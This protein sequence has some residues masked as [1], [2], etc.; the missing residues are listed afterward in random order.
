[1]KRFLLPVVLASAVGL[2]WM[3]APA[4]A[5]WLSEA[6]HTIRGDYPV[7]STPAYD[8]VG[9]SY[10]S[11][12]GYVYTTPYYY[13]YYYTPNPSYYWGG[14]YWHGGYQGWH[15]EYHG[16]HGDYH[17]RHEGGHGGHGRGHRH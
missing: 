16:R 15:G 1:M 6:V 14:T 7:Y 8:Y 2:G 13:D 12:P 3:P 5:S 11:T 9:P 17:D 10:Y 4:H